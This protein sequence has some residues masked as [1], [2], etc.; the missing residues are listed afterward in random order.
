LF[1][2]SHSNKRENIA[3]NLHRVLFF[4]DD[5]NVTCDLSCYFVL[6]F[7]NITLHRDYPLELAS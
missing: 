5:D 3:Y 7:C 2:F 4:V 6:P 1:V